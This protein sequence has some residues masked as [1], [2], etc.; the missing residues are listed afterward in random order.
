M[1]IVEIYERYLKGEK[2]KSISEINLGNLPVK[3]PA[4]LVGQSPIMQKLAEKH[5]KYLR[6]YKK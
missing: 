3:Q 6:I 1:K 2:F 4:D 5:S